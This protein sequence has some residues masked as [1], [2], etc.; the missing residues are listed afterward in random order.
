MTNNINKSHFLAIEEHRHIELEA[1]KDGLD[2]MDLAAEA[3]THYIEQ[4]QFIKK[5]SI[6]ILVGKGNN[7]GDGVSCAIKLIKLGYSITLLLIF[8]KLSPNTAKL[9]EKFK[10]LNG[11]VITELPANISQYEVIIDAVIGI[12]ISSGLDNKTQEIFN[13]INHSGKFILAIDTPSGV[14]PFTGNVYPGAIKV[15]TTLTFIAD[16]PGLYTAGAIDYVGDVVV[17]TLNNVQSL[18]IRHK[19]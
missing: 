13:K 8:D 2:L 17:D 14:N 18:Y 15:N 1:E 7:G 6:L 9:I 11:T 19:I 16:K 5:K 4:L 12:G 10:Q 3:I